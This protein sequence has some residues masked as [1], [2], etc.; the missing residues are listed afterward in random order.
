MAYVKQIFDK[1]FLEYASYVIKDRA[2]PDIEDGLKPVQR[3]ILYT[4]Y[5]MDDGT[6]HKVAAAVGQTMFLHPH[7]DASINEALVNLANK[8]IFMQKQGNFGNIAT[9]DPAAAARYIECALLPFAKNL[10]FKDEITEFV[11]SYDGKMKEPVTLPVKIPLV[12]MIGAEGI[13]VGMSTKILPHNFIEVLKAVRCA[14]K[15]EEFTLYPDFPLGGLVDPA[16]YND[17]LGKVIVRAK[18]DLSDNKRIVIRE[19]PFGVTVETMIKSIEEAAKK[20]KIKIAGIGDFTAEN[21][22]IAIDLPRG[23]YAADVEEALYAFTHCEVSISVNCLVIKDRKPEVIP[24]SNIIHYHAERLVSLLKLELELEKSELLAKVRN[25]TLDRIFIEERIYKQIEEQKSAAAIEKAIVAGFEPYVGKEFEGELSKE[26]IDRLLQIPIRRISLFDIEK[27][28][29]ELTAMLKRVKEIDKLLANLTAYASDYLTNLIEEHKE[30]FPRR[31]GIASFKK[32]DVREAAQRNLKLRFDKESGYLGY[33]VSGGELIAEVSSYDRVLV[34]RADTS[35]QVLE[36]P[37]K[38]F[39]GKDPITITLA[40]KEELE[41]TIYNIVYK[42]DETGFPY[43]KR[44]KITTYLTGKIYTHILPEGCSLLAFGKGN[45]LVIIPQFAQKQLL[46]EEKYAVKDYLVKG[47]TAGG[48]RLKAKE[49]VGAKFI[50][51]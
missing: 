48:V 35:Y 38:S 41:K 1:N 4:L 21:V 30:S 49:A 18:L 43:I 34:M 15:G 39:V 42:N 2:I 50:N 47:V 5:R 32:V 36:V 10:F 45:D 27:N 29:K 40:D 11:P 28:R 46:K 17:G 19:L 24:V 23:V 22:E 20:N 6:M 3:R 44:F 9:G 51:G 14:L 12:L 8:D 33:N 25:R 26:D 37:E 7:G 16:G 31:A 13:A